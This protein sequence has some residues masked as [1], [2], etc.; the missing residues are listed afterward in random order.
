MTFENAKEI[1]ETAKN[2][3]LKNILVETDSPYLTPAPHRGKEENEP[4]F[5]QHV[6]D[7]IIALRNEKERA[8]KASQ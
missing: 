2:I 1:Q 6:L 8:M 7:K 5:T 4:A 3:P